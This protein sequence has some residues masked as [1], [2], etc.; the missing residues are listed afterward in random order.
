[1]GD[2]EKMIELLKEMQQQIVSLQTKVNETQQ[3]Q[4]QHTTAVDREVIEDKDRFW[5]SCQTFGNN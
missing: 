2:K 3:Q 5:E 4:K 1:M